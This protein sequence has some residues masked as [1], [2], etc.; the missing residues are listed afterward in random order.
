M[1]CFIYPK[2]SFLLKAVMHLKNVIVVD[3]APDFVIVSSGASKSSKCHSS[4]EMMFRNQ[5]LSLHL[6]QYWNTQLYE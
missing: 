6:L 3:P 2:S 5:A 4:L 1:L